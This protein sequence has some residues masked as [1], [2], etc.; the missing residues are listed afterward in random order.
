MKMRPT[1]AA[2]PNQNDMQRCPICLLGLRVKQHSFADQRHYVVGCRQCGAQTLLPYP[3][4]EEV[5]RIYH[6]WDTTRTPEDHVDLLINRH[7]ELYRNLQSFIDFDLRQASFL[8]V[9]FGNGTSLL[10]AAKFGI[11]QVNGVDLDPQNILD[12]ERRAT[13]LDLPVKCWQGD[14]V[15][16]IPRGHYQFITAFQL[17]EHLVNPIA[18]IANLAD[19]QERGDYLYLECPNN[20]AAFWK[21]KNG[22]SRRFNR[23]DFYNSLKINLH[24]WG[25]DRK[26]MSK[27]LHHNGYK[28]VFCRDYHMRH[29]YFHPENLLAYPS[30]GTGIVRSMA[31]RQAYPVLKSFIGAFDL[32]ASIAGRGMGLAALARRV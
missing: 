20:G 12:T 31:L 14:A 25:F 10:G 11:T 32:V 7:V 23:L 24:L 16:G 19:R 18:F 3:T 15:T 6:N 29:P 1:Q 26:S 13:G 30:L 8:E 21:L 17:I 27:L 28:V 5:G 22:L 4:A 2:A 9:G